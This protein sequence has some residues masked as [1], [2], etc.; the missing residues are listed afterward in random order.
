M[1]TS[2]LDTDPQARATCTCVICGSSYVAAKTTA[3]R[4]GFCA[5]T[6]ERVLEKKHELNK[7]VAKMA[8]RAAKYR[9]FN[10]ELDELRRRT[11]GADQPPANPDPFTV[12]L[13][14]I[15]DETGIE[16]FFRDEVERQERMAKTATLGQRSAS[17][18]TRLTTAIAQA[19]RGDKTTLRRALSAIR[20]ACEAS[21]A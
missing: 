6:C 20:E 18:T 13:T 15:L 4:R 17:L 5:S 3:E 2:T 7:P 12:L 11:Q 9:A 1:N 16:P 10:A 14:R 21:A 8:A 19:K